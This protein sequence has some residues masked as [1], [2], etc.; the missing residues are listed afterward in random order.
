MTKYINGR[1]ITETAFA[2]DGCHKIY[3]LHNHQYDEYRELDYTLYEIDDL[4][5]VWTDTCPLR[6]INSGDL[7]EK[8]VPQFTP[9]KFEGWDIP[10]DLQWEL[11]EMEREQNEANEEE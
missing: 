2:F 11:D 7:T 1:A 5:R 10:L 4:P 9:A 6:F 3:L 8:I